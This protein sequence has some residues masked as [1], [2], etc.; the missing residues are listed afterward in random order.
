MVTKINR[1][2]FLQGAGLGFAAFAASGNRKVLAN[3]YGMPIGLQLYT[4]RD[5]M[6]KDLA[7]TLKKVAEIGY[8]E[9]ELGGFNYYGQKPADLRRMLDDHGL[10][11]VSAHYTES[12][13]K[14]NLEKHI[15][16]AKVCGITYIGLASLDDSDR[17]S[18]DVIKRAAEWFNQVGETV[19]VAGCRFFYHGHNFDYATVDGAVV[20][21]ELI[22]RTEPRAVNFE[23]DCF[24]CVRAGKDPVDYFQRFPGRFPQLHIKDLKPGYP[25]TT[26][27]DSRPGAFTEVG[28]GVIDWK[29][30]FKAAPGGGMKH[31]YVE[32][33]EC[34]RDTL[35]SARISYDYLHQLSI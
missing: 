11:T 2:R 28:Q 13:L 22:R 3:P 25:P 17:K 6:E 10:K 21:D 26:G 5:H 18:L 12:Q 20:Y 8:R 15:A 24:W 27:E 30:I 7:G 1:R 33:D 32:Q 23:M 35:E 34:D 29:K 16:E 19:R 4:V 9:V 31:F 14:S